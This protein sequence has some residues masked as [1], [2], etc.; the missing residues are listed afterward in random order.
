[1]FSRV[2]VSRSGASASKGMVTLLCTPSVLTA[3]PASWHKVRSSWTHSS[4]G[5]RSSDVQKVIFKTQV[6][7]PDFLAFF[8]ENAGFFPGWFFKSDFQNPDSGSGVF[9]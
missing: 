2:N 9:Y 1:M 7:E 5:I 4:E 8:T 6:R 3:S